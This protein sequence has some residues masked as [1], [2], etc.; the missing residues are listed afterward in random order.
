MGGKKRLF[1]S[2]STEGG[3]DITIYTKNVS[4]RSNVMFGNM[5]GFEKVGTA[6]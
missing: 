4:T 2:A 3:T 5:E 1:R 6:L